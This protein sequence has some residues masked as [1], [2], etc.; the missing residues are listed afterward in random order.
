MLCQFSFQNF[1]SYKNETIFDM[2]ATAIPEFSDSPIQRA[3]YP[4]FLPVSVFYGPNGG[5]KS[6]FLQA[7][8]FLIY[9]IVWPV[10]SLGMNRTEPIIQ[11]KVS[12]V[13]FL[14]DDDSSDQP[15]E[16]QIFFYIKGWEYRYY[17]SLLDEEIIAE[18][19]DRKANDD[20]PERLYYREGSEIE[21]GELLQGNAINTSVNP[22][23]AFLSF[24][25]I[26]YNLPVITDVQKWFESCVIRS[27]VCPVRKEEVI[28]PE[29]AETKQQIIAMLNGM[30]IDI[31]NYRYDKTRKELF[32]T[33]KIG[34]DEYTLPYS[35]ESNGTQKLLA[36]LPLLLAALKE[37]RLL[38]MDELDAKLHPKLLRYIIS[39]F[40]DTEINRHGAQ[41]LFTSHDIYTLR[42]TVFRQ[43]EIWFAALD[44][45]H[46]SEIYS[47]SDI[48][49]TDGTPIN[50]K[51]DFDRDYLAGRY[52]ADPYLKKMLKW[53]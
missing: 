39:L 38:I 44:D 25:S 7:I 42:N 18:V 26:N 36:M 19:L 33:R 3:P 12:C 29:D 21:L 30:D 6:N 41:L 2:R 50:N 23:M 11:D 37:G 43:D 4:D 22:K 31:T 53:R 9:F 8:S 28:I 35:S 13:P 15:T 51:S 46:S 47:L 1:K 5:G 48:H 20:Q 16:F 17:L 40:R 45:E 49:E 10:R 27:G 52:G 24:L 14:F 32:L 34:S